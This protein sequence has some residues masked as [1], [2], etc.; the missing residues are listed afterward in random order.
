MEKT[1][2]PELVLHAECRGKGLSKFVVDPPEGRHSF[3]IAVYC[4]HTEAVPSRRAGSS[5]SHLAALV[6]AMLWLF[7]F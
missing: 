6:Q 5:L 7:T 2:K 4:R 3:R 1:D